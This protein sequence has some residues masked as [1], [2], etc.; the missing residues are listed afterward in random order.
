MPL[1]MM[2]RSSPFWI[3][4]ASLGS[5]MPSARAEEPPCPSQITQQPTAPAAVPTPASGAASTPASG[6]ASTP[7]SGAASTPASGAAP[8]NAAPPQPSEHGNIEITSDE[9]TLSADGNATL[10]GNVEAR[11]GN[12]QIRANHIEYDSKSGSMRTEGHFEFEDPVVRITGAGGSYSAAAG[13]DFRSAEFSLRQR[14]ARGSARELSLTPQGT[15]DL[16]GVTF[17]TCPQHDESWR[18]RADSIVLD[19]H[20]KIGTGRDA[21]V[22]FMGVPLMY[23]PWL[24]FPLSSE[25]KSGFLFPTVGNTSIN[26]VQL[27]VPYYWNIQPNVDFTFQPVLY[28]KAGVDLGGD[29]RF[30]TEGQ[31]GD[32]NWNYLPYDKAFGA[33]RSRVQFNDIAELPNDFRVNVSAENV[34]DRHYFEDFSTGPEGAS[35]AFV[36]RRAT[37]SY[38]SE[39]WSM[40]ASAQEYQTIDYT[41][42]ETDRPYARVPRIVVGADYRLGPGGLLHYGF[43]SEVVNFQHVETPTIVTSGWRAD[44]MP[45]MAF[46][47]TGPGYF[48][49]PAIAWRGTQY[50]LDDL[51]SGQVERSPSRTLPITSLDTGLLFERPA[52][53][54]DQRKLT[55]E[56]R[57]FYLDVPYRDQGQLPVFD[58][59]VPDLN[60]VQLFRTNRYVGADRVSDANQVSFAL[61]SRLLD[62][63]SGRQFIAGMFGQTYYFETPRVTL[64]GEAPVTARHSDF[65]AQLALTAFEDWSADAAVQWDP[66]NQRSE[67][68][69]VNL[70]YKP[71]P[72]KV[73]NLSYRYERFTTTTELVPELVNG[74]YQSVPEPVEQ[75]YD[76]VEF[77]GAWPIQRNWSLFLREVYALRNPQ[78]APPATV[79]PSGEIERFIGFEY[80][81]CCWRVRLGARR[82]V[83]N[84]D[85]SQNTGVWV[86]LELSGLAGVGSASDASLSEEIRGYRAP[87]TTTIK[88][89]GPLK[90]IW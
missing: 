75:G 55:L 60:P 35:T 84:R 31:R 20:T 74:T 76:Q 11:Q 2:L 39:H 19:T 1:F 56:P 26:G 29:L 38:R 41:L 9:A 17:T 81:A 66:Q 33:S 34:S 13:A 32:L 18:I 59:A 87:G 46:D 23:M 12:R 85:G 30:L 6:A 78:P 71:A 52:G 37:L 16:R 54:H 79:E 89:Q 48:L 80:R 27:A 45:F 68:T 82:Y 8:A 64:P 58:T 49:R 28:S 14:A 62:A 5:I 83:S 4:I 50:E 69:S 44:V 61:T 15:L 65:V 7:A 88:A 63:R 47:L 77:S 22:D 24:S 40:D 72:N 67:R 36:E 42:A 21:R 90:S 25:R 70:Q 73:L 51:A 86:Q 53:S 43:D 3:V 10:R 57:I